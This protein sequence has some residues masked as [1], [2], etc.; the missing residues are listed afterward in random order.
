M[1]SAEERCERRNRVS[2]GRT[3]S[4]QRARYFKTTETKRVKG[5]SNGVDT[6][7]FDEAFDEGDVEMLE[8]GYHRKFLSFRKYEQIRCSLQD[9]R[10]RQ[11]FEH[12]MLV[13]DA[14]D[15]GE[16]M[17]FSFA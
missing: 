12:L 17:I 10:S 9:S 4:K 14:N 13:E 3:M 16:F 11:H 8:P 5:L 15:A 2:I 1:Q 7:D 6:L